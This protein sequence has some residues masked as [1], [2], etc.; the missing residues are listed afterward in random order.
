MRKESTLDKWRE[1]Y[2]LAAKIRTMEPWKEFQDLDII[3]IEIPHI[4]EPFFCS[5]LGAG[6]QCFGINTF[7]G[8]DG[9]RNFLSIA[10]S[11]SYMPLDY[12]MVEQNNLACFFGE[13]DA[14]PEEEKSI[15]KELGIKFRGKNKWIYFQ[16]YKKGHIPSILDEEEIDILLICLK[17]L[18]NVIKDYRRFTLT[19]DFEAGDMLLRRFYKET[20]KWKTTRERLT[21]SLYGYPSL[22]LKDELL[23]AKIKRKS[24]V[25][26]ILEFDM[27]YIKVSIQDDIH[28]RPIRPKL[29]LLVDHYEGVIV[30]QH[31][32]VPGNDEIQ[33]IMELFI[34]YIMEFGRPME[35]YIRNPFIENILKHTC[36]ICGIKLTM[37]KTL[38]V[39]DA[40]IDGFEVLGF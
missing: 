29:L 23:A 8:Y 34:N 3:S 17:E 9:L 31:F 19:I 21:H 35:I 20:G 4:K 7:I 22:I 10:D 37:T 6:G 39:V 11:E 15:M 38:E 33:I 26:A 25:E 5:I 18:I 24:R 1:L 12:I 40:F 28:E 2:K 14:V 13:K 30:G 27:I 36:E 16:S 32:F